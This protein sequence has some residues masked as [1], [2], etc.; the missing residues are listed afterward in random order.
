MDYLKVIDEVFAQF[1][2][3][4]FSIRL[5][6]GS[7]R[8]Y[9]SGTAK[10]F[11]L[12]IDDAQTARRLIAEGAL[13]FGEA[14]ME[15][16]LRIEGD[17]EAYLRLRHQFRHVRRSWRLVLAT[18]L[19]KATS[20]YGRKGQIAQ[21]Y[22]LG[23]DFFRMVLDP[24]TM[25]Y[26]AGRYEEGN[27]SLSQAQS[28]KLEYICE[29]LD[30]PTHAR[31][32]DLGSGWGGFAVHAAKTR[33]VRTVGYTLSN[34]QREYCQ[35]LVVKE[36][37]EDLATFEYRD[38]VSR[39]QSDQFDAIVAIESIEHVGKPKLMPFFLELYQALKPGGSA[40]IQVTGRY[41]PRAVDPWTLKYVFPGGYLPAKEELLRGAASAGFSVK[42]FDD[43]T[44]DY[45]HTM[46]DWIQNLEQN[47]VAI[48]RKFDPAFYRLWE[49]WMHGARAAFSVG[50]MRLFRIH[51]T[52]P[53]E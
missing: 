39:I 16:K 50:S 34:A 3:P 51:L 23:N 7:E 43:D 9:G 32:L 10:A 52:K 28:R 37:V 25:S 1:T 13:G 40:Y 30:L 2:G 11:T 38:M 36:R 27:E 31:V 18:L 12:V 6:D 45:I 35:E 47:R 8:Y 42:R 48:E 17:I 33:G 15:N 26:S 14:Y 4:R 21:H 41:Q 24:E 20:P 5:W 44:S 22:D 29:L 19:A 53:T 46:G 49:L